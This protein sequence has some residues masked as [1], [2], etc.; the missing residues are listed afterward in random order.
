MTIGFFGGI[1]G[2]D[3]LSKSPPLTLYTTNS[4]VIPSVSEESPY[5]L[6]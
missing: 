1:S 6:Q 2:G 3:L 5:S 4:S